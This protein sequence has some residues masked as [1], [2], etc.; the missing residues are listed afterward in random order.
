MNIYK[1][2]SQSNLNKKMDYL[3]KVD[4]LDIVGVLCVQKSKH[5]YGKNKRGVPIYLFK[6]FDF[7][8]PNFKVASK[9]TGENEYIVIKILRIDKSGLPFGENIGRKIGKVSNIKST[10]LAL[11]HHYQ[12]VFKKYNGPIPQ[13]DYKYIEQSDNIISI[14]P[15]GCIDID[16][17]VSYGG[18]KLKIYLADTTKIN[19]KILEHACNQC[20]T[21]YDSE[22][23]Q[24]M[25]PE[26]MM[27][28]C[29]L[30]QGEYRIANICEI[31]IDDK[32]N[33]INYRF[34]QDI[35]K[36]RKNY[37]YEEADN[38]NEPYLETI[39][40][41]VEHIKFD[42]NAQDGTRSH[43][44]IEKMMVLVNN[45]VVNE[46]KKTGKE[47][48]IR[49]HTS[50][51]LDTKE[52]P[53]IFKSFFNIYKSNSAEYA[54][55]DKDAKHYGLGIQEYTH[56]TSPL[57]RLVDL[58]NHLVLFTDKI[59]TSDEL[60]QICNNCNDTNK[61]IKRYNIESNKINLLI[62]EEVVCYDGYIIDFVKKEDNFKIK[63]YIPE[64]KLVLSHKL[65]NDK[66]SSLY[67]VKLVNEKLEVINDNKKR[68]YTFFEKI[69]VT[70]H[71]RPDSID[72]RKKLVFELN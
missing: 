25:L 72:F 34:I 45:L 3:D 18:N 56:F 46:L 22:K 9:I 13:I 71:K 70:V 23:I 31:N 55:Y 39:M 12:L 67:K 41:I 7:E 20:T 16:D 30:L 68:E 28:S 2:I 8:L 66:L 48:I 51:N 17:A 64:L 69:L 5:K 36:V 32:Y 11:L 19:D 62:D 53:N 24:H 21:I 35:I 1:M 4:Q 52:V 40:H 60:K 44:V 14:D 15:K 49:K 57:R 43:K 10:K 42:Y 65:Y 47:F 58:I 26:K 54:L 33:I 37:S 59:F 61:R 63:F 38:M 6:P 27:K 50:N 29:S